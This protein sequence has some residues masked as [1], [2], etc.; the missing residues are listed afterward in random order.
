VR[1]KLFGAILG[2]SVLALIV[3][4]VTSPL[5][6]G[7][8]ISAS[9]DIKPET[10]NHNKQGKWITSYIELPEGYNITDVAPSTILLEGLFSP[11]WANVEGSRLMVK[12]DAPSVI[13]YLWSV[14]YHMGGYRMHVELTITGQLSNGMDFSGSD[15]ITIM[16]PI[17]P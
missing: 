16:N 8:S 10:L 12:F 6:K 14:L 9:V 3:F 13:D 2:L 5:G 11:E 15:T 1:A 7:F 4:Q 17:A